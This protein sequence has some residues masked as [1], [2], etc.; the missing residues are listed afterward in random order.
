MWGKQKNKTEVET[1]EQALFATIEEWQA[2]KAAATP[3][4]DDLIA[5]AAGLGMEPK[6]LLTHERAAATNW[7]EV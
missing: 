1:S 6:F 7:I 5:Q 2:Q 3:T 4:A